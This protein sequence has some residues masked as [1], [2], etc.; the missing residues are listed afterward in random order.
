MRDF[1]DAKAMTQSLREALSQRHV[2]LA[3][4]E[5]LELVSKMLGFS[6]WNSLAAFINTD[7]G[8]LAQSKI[9]SNTGATLPVLPIK[10]GVLFPTVQMPLWI[11]RP[12]LFKP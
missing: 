2:S 9:P 12:K 3:N 5:T 8:E 1:R 11:K 6:D 4:S 10:D 7:R